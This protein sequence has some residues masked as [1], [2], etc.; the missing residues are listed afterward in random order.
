MTAIDCVKNNLDQLKKRAA[1]MSKYYFHRV[2]QENGEKAKKEDYQ[3]EIDCIAGTVRK[4]GSIVKTINANFV[5]SNPDFRP[6]WL[7]PDL[8]DEKY[9][10]VGLHCCGDLSSV[11]AELSINDSRIVGLVLV[12][13]CYHHLTEK[14][15]AL[16][17]NN[18][19]AG[20]CDLSK[21]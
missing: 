4:R 18:P 19:Q 3:I 1:L 8:P 9:V 14:C 16:E 10:L 15:D 12:P 13:C 17:E 7:P 20:F 5:V 2:S 6:G 21:T 11:L